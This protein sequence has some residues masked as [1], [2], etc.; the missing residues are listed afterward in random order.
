MVDK[1]RNVLS[2]EL[3]YQQLWVQFSEPETLHV[4]TNDTLLTEIPERWSQRLLI[5]D[6]SPPIL[7]IQLQLAEGE[8]LYVATLLPVPDFLAD[9]QLRSPQTLAYLLV[10]LAGVIGLSFLVIRQQTRPL[11]FMLRAAEELGQDIGHDPIPETGSREIRATA[12]VFNQMQA[13]IQTYLSD[14]EH[15][16]T[17]MSHDLKTPITRMRIR[18]EL[19][20][21]PQH[22]IKFTRDLDEV[23]QMVRG[24]LQALRDTHYEEDALA[25]DLSQLIED[26]IEDVAGQAHP[27]SLNGSA[28]PSRSNPCCLSGH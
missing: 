3:T 25:T 18:T 19:L 28:A 1:F 21:K 2:S 16:F 15:F 10:F 9:M 20:E 8:W 22:R 24:A 26:V 7:V 23:E 11:T 4:H 13:R 17:A 5:D 27:I 6:L 14:R 12:R